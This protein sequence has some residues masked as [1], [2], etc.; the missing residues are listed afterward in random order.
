MASLN[1]S[2]FLQQRRAAS[3]G[4][5]ESFQNPLTQMTASQ[6]VKLH[7]VMTLLGVEPRT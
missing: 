6:A 5:R 3:G 1:F 7:D 2:G 4:V